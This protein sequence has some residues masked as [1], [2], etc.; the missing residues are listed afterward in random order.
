MRPT[1]QS[2]TV[3]KAIVLLGFFL[4]CVCLDRKTTEIRKLRD[5]RDALAQRVE[6]L[7]LQNETQR[8]VYQNDQ[9][10]IKRLQ[11]ILERVLGSEA[12][13]Y[14]D[15]RYFDNAA[16]AYAKGYAEG[17]IHQAAKAA[18]AAEG[19]AAIEA[20]KGL[21]LRVRTEGRGPAGRETEEA[22]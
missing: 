19:K 16:K 8:R 5:E 10:L 9:E 12:G 17:R 7:T 20:A 4:L 18:R 21:A 15:I 6:V 2:R 14:P 11:K 3:Y 1:P 13:G 22:E